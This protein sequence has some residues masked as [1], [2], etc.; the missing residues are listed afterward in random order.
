M[1]ITNGSLGADILNGT[2]DADSIYGFGSNAGVSTGDTI[3]GADG[4]DY[5]EATNAGDA[6]DDSIY[7]GLGD[8]TIVGYD[9]VGAAGDII[10]G[11][12]GTDIIVNDLRDADT[13][14]GDGAGGRIDN[15]A[16]ADANINNVEGVQVSNASDF[17]LTFGVDTIFGFD[18]TMEADQDG[19]DTIDDVGPTDVDGATFAGSTTGVIDADGVVANEAAG[20]VIDGTT[21]G[22]GDSFTTTG[23]GTVDIAFDGVNDVWQ[24]TYTPSLAQILG[25]GSN[26]AGDE[27]DDQTVVATITEDGTGD[28]FTV[29]TTFQYSLEKDLDATSQTSDLTILGR[30]PG[31]PDPLRF[32]RRL[33]ERQRRR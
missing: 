13:L 21:Y 20:I 26:A 4:N 17:L 6:A 33:P 18:L 3:N 1:A 28:T 7:G 10:D 22:D 31:Q 30:R 11:G 25:V 27:T 19:D 24:F 16:Y 5:I 8:D 15:A 2:N 29:S 32:W 14:L 23:G 9:S 12:D